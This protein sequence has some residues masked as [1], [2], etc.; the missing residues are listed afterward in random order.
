MNI[1]KI[2]GF[3]IVSVLLIIILKEEKKEFAFLLVIISSVLIILFGLNEMSKIIDLLENLA[4]KSGIS[5]DYLII[6]LKIT[7]IAYVVEFGK[8][9]CIDSGQTAIASKLEMVGKVIIISLS[10]PVITSLLSVISGLVI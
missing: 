1:F 9:I 4:E 6:I 8:N 2:V 3:A 7:G 10:I 5:K